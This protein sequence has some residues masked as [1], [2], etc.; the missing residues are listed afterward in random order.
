[1][2]WDGK[3]KLSKSPG[4]PPVEESF[5]RFNFPFEK[6]KW[7]ETEENRSLTDSVLALH[8]RES[9]FRLL[10]K[11]LGASEMRLGFEFGSWDVQVIL[12]QAQQTSLGFIRRTELITAPYVDDHQ[13]TITLSPTSDANY[14]VALTRYHV[15]SARPKPERRLLYQ[16]TGDYEAGSFNI[17]R[18]VHADL[19]DSSQSLLT[20]FNQLGLPLA[21]IYHNDKNILDSRHRGGSPWLPNAD[22]YNT[23]RLTIANLQ[24]G[25]Q[26]QTNGLPILLQV[27]DAQ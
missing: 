24:E 19:E 7:V 27:Q 18:I 6:N 4:K 26:P 13:E 23:A 14:E 20:Y 16:L 10:V 21:G 1:M 5:E 25:H 2:T 12:R 11:M 15:N 8:G 22:W 3:D 9:Q 17:T